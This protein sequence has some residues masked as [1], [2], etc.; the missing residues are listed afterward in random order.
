[1][2]VRAEVRFGDW[3]GIEH[4]TD[5]RPGIV[6]TTTVVG[7]IL[8]AAVLSSSTAGTPL[9]SSLNSIEAVQ[10]PGALAIRPCSAIDYQSLSDSYNVTF[11]ESGLANGTKWAVELN[12][13]VIYSTARSIEFSALVTGT[14]TFAV[15][16]PTDYFASPAAGTI[17]VTK[18]LQR[19]INFFE[20]GS[21]SVFN[22]TFTETGLPSGTAWSVTLGNTT[23][24][25]TSFSLTI[26]EPNGS[27]EFGVPTVLAYSAAPSSGRVLVSGVPIS[28]HVSF[29]TP[30][31]LG[32]PPAEGYFVISIGLL[33]L[34]VLLAILGLVLR[35]RGRIFGQGSP[36]SSESSSSPNGSAPPPSRE[37]A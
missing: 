5:A 18:S 12:G 22:V 35:R 19:A 4:V 25:S 15:G 8:A 14:Y 1:M 6:T 28:E 31:V 10:G 13:S 17:N 36:P 33:G 34:V 23:A 29:S 11:H 20:F 30:K 26:V 3:V 37:E 32:L 7:L 24:V 27:Y 9:G 16:S 21:G 2:K